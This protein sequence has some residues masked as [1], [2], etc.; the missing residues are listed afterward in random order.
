MRKVNMHEAKSSLSELVR[1]SLEGEDVVVARNGEP[2]V[3]LV[4]FY[5]T[6]GLRPV[7]LH[8]LPDSAADETF[9]LE[10]MRPLDPEELE[11]WTLPVLP[12]PDPA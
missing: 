1:L 10:S 6:A 9:A 12:D 11:A 2:V 8:R 4:P 7:G 5:P 3:R